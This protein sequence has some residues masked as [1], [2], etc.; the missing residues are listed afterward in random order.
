MD[1]SGQNMPRR[2][3]ET[4]VRGQGNGSETWNLADEPEAVEE[5]VELKSP[6][7]YGKVVSNCSELSK[8]NK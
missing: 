6:L 4:G 2:F 8:R 1:R 5:S 7:R 3:S